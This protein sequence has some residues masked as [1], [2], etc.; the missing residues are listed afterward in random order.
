MRPTILAVVE[1]AA[2]RACVKEVL[3]RRYAADYEVSCR[4]S[5]PQAERELGES[6]PQASKS[7]S[8]RAQSP[9]ASY[10]TLIGQE[11]S[12]R[13]HELRTLLASSGIAYRF[14]ERGSVAAQRLLTG[15]VEEHPTSF[16]PVVVVRDGRV[17]HDP[18]SA[19]EGFRRGD[20]ARP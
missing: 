13:V 9:T 19:R 5:L 4:S 20:R 10:A 3:R 7:P 12:P 2:D 15:V 17:F 11:G 18:S 1:G 16:A 14:E 8:S 6:A